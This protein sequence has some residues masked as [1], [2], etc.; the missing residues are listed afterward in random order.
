MVY[1]QYPEVTFQGRRYTTRSRAIREALLGPAIGTCE[2]VGTDYQTGN[3][4]TASFEARQITGISQERLIA[5]EMDGAF[6]VYLRSGDQPPAT[7]GQLMD[8]FDLTNTLKL[9]CF[10]RCQGYDS[11]GYYSLSDGTA[12]WQIISRCREATL[13]ED[14]SGWNVSGRRHLSFTATAEALGCYK[15]ALYVTEDGYLWTNLRNRSL[16]Y[17]IGTDAAAEIIHYAT[18]NAAEATFEPYEYTLT[19]TLTEIGDGYIL[20]DDSILCVNE[21]DGLV[22]RIL[23]GD[24]RAQRCIDYGGLQ[25]GDVIVVK[26]SEPIN[27]T[28][29]T[30]ISGAHAICKGQII[31][32]D[33][34]IPE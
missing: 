15:K 7:L 2:A 22:F 33:V 21:Q 16:L 23:T 19:G 34:A 9:S 10:S 28:T 26:F 25:V 8:E 11:E 32:G 17:H 4:Y 14:R 13:V 30:P 6:Y 29:D 5:L 12:L 1:E 20:L 18:Q 27:P 3:T 24:R 31:D